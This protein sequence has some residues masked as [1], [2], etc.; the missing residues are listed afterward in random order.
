MIQS[1][2]DTLTM[3]PTK[4]RDSRVRNVPPPE[5]AD[6]F[7]L[8]V[9]VEQYAKFLPAGVGEDVSINTKDKALRYVLDR[10]ALFRAR[11]ANMAPTTGRA[12]KVIPLG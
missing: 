2:I 8:L 9:Q 12:A 1:S 3:M 10:G 6:S 7:R 4:N 11:G 5:R